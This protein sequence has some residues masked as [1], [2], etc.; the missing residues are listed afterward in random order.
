M[1]N[2]SV[3]IWLGLTLAAAAPLQP[4]SAQDVPP[5]TPTTEAKPESKIITTKSGLKYEDLAVGDGAEAKKKKDVTV[6]YRGTLEDGTLFD[7]S[8]GREPFTFKL[9]AGQVIKGWDE[10]VK[11]MKEGGKRRLVIP[12]KLGYGSTGT[13]GGPIPPD[14]TL[15]FEVELIKVK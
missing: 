6:N 8:Y 3:P 1:K 9:G 14:A 12:A 4:V 15:I 13:P 10:G 2:L 7:E 5:S 11:G